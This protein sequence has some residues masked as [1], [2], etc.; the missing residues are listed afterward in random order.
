MKRRGDR[1]EPLDAGMTLAEM[2]VSIGLF[3]LVG[4]LVTATTVFTLRSVEMSQVRVDQS[5]QGELA[6]AAAS[7][8]LRTAVLPEQLEAQTCSDCEETAITAATGTR[9]KF[10]ANLNNTGGGPSL[11]TLRVEQDPRNPKVSRLMQDTQAPIALSDGSY[12]FCNPSTSGCVVQSRIIGR[13]LLFPVTD[14]FTYYDYDG[15]SLGSGTLTGDNLRKISSV[16]VVV[17]VRTRPGEAKHPSRTAL[18]R[19]RLPNVEINVV[20]Q[21]VS[22]T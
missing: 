14:V 22:P 17:T 21:S 2:I 8:V 16:D 7:K 19:V 12:T 5:S 13:S 1:A 11:V 10:Y 9:V 15:A 20:N 18:T 4:A 6:V 3:V